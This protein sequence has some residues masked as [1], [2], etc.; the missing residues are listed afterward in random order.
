MVLTFQAAQ[1]EEKAQVQIPKKC[2][3]LREKNLL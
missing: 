3:H 1:L 2:F